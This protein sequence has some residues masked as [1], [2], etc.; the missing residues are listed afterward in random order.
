MCKHNGENN[1]ACLNT[2]QQA[3]KRKRRSGWLTRN[4]KPKTP[5][6]SSGSGA[7]TGDEFY[8]PAYFFTGISKRRKRNRP[9]TFETLDIPSRPSTPST[10]SS[11]DG[12][13]A[14]STF[15]HPRSR[16]GEVTSANMT[17][18]SN[19]AL[20]YN[21]L[22]YSPMSNQQTIRNDTSLRT[23][24]D[25]NHQQTTPALSSTGT[26]NTIRGPVR[27]RG[28]QGRSGLHREAPGLA[29]NVQLP[30]PQRSQNQ[31]RVDN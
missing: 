24:P 22:S 23:T 3:N 25:N 20:N 2:L 19:Y 21:Y 9:S 13:T 18:E 11:S 28:N 14:D 15:Y 12:W 7:W 26:N 31:E 6:E 29:P 17:G 8:L 4:W 5:S 10:P 1:S 27:R 30:F 16:R